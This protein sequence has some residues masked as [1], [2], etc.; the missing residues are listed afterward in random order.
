MKQFPAGCLFSDLLDRGQLTPDLMQALAHQV[1]AFHQRAAV[2]DRIKSFG[3]IPQIRAAFDE[4]YAQSQ[5]Y[6]GRGQT[7]QQLQATQAY[8]DQAFD[9]WQERFQKRIQCNKI[10][11]CH[12]DLHLKNIC[13]WQNR[14]FLFDCIEFN[15][16]FRY[17]DTMYDVAFTAMDCDA[18]GRMDLGNVF[19]NTYLEDTGDW[20][21]AALLP[22]YLSRQ[23]Y[24]RAKVTSFLLDEPTLTAD[25][26]QA[27]KTQAQAYYT[28]AWRY[29][30]LRE[31]QLIL[32]SGLSGTGKSTV[33]RR[34]AQLIGAIHIRS[35]AVRKHLAGI[36][37]RQRG[38]ASI[39]TP[40]MTEKTYDRLCEL[41]IRLAKLGHTVILDAKYDRIAT[42]QA[43]LTQANAA[44]I[45]VAIVVC[46]APMTVLYQRL[47]QRVGDITDAT[48]QLLAS[49]R[50]TAQGLTDDEQ[51]LATY[52]DTTTNIE[53]EIQ[54]IAA[55]LTSA[56]EITLLHECS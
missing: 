27:I 53:T 41:G 1:A 54:K 16:A 28:L 50:A 43:V 6:I 8:T 26:S 49:Q 36:S 32:M 35:D 4:N 12:G 45:P 3:T 5:A 13:L 7:Q 24:V 31:G 18:Q 15:E 19:L 20:E 37:L 34:L 48:T 11:E 14:I 22:L 46:T 33:A 44:D 10:R 23:A 42:R 17:V 29:T 9:Q 30:Q 52:I 56:F 25:Q 21:G 47:Q 38:D 2:S 39:Y 51:S 55:K 40:A